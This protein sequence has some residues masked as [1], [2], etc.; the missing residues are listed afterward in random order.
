VLLH[1]IVHSA[2]PG[3]A[4]RLGVALALAAGAAA[5]ILGVVVFFDVLEHYEEP[6]LARLT[7]WRDDA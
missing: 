2:L 6:E 5:A 4:A 3:Q 1:G 7:R